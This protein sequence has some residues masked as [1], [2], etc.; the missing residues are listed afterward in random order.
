MSTVLALR[1]LFPGRLLRF[2]FLNL[3]SSS[4]LVDA[5]LSRLTNKLIV[6]IVYS[7][8]V[9]SR[10]SLGS[11]RDLKNAAMWLCEANEAGDSRQ[12]WS[13]I[14]AHAKRWKEESGSKDDMDWVSF[15]VF[16]SWRWIVNGLTLSPLFKVYCYAENPRG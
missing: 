8:D 3:V 6:S 16:K 9:V 15:F 10:L 2:L 5:A 4:A 11:I 13:A 1:K 12:G 14:I 7:H